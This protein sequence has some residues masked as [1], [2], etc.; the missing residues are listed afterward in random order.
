M[1]IK[2]KAHVTGK[3][4]TPLQS[5]ADNAAILASVALQLGVDVL[6]YSVTGPILIALSEF[7]GGA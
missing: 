3:L 7:S 2:E 4:G 6:R 5:S 1:P